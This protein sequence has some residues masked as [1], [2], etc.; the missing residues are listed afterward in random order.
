MPTQVSATVAPMGG[1]VTFLVSGYATGVGAQMT[2]GRSVGTSGGP[3]TALYSGSPVY[4][5]ID[6][7]D[8][9][10]TPLSSGS[11]YYW[12]FTDSAGSI[13]V[14]PLQPTSSIIYNPESL[15]SVI[16][17]CIQAGISNIT[18][19]AGIK[20]ATVMHSMPLGNFPP[21][22]LISVALRSQEQENNGIGQTARWPIAQENNVWAMPAL[23]RKIWMISI[24]AREV[25]TRD[26]Y[27]KVVLDILEAMLPDIFTGLGSNVTNSFLVSSGT[28]T[29]EVH[30]IAPGFY[31]ADI[32]M[33]LTGL[34]NVSVQLNYPPVVGILLSATASGLTV[35]GE[36]PAQFN[37]SYT[38]TP[39]PYTML[40]TIG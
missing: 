28:E 22:P 5:Y 25:D 19:P 3:Y 12:N 27:R 17:R 11:N 1:I 10:P 18:A 36:T 24:L 26:Y 35:F 33:E 32:M 38:G 9:L 37:P 23:A 29:D 4:F 8:G 21:L 39:N 2:V 20:P 31:Y 34:F 6:A 13:V 30:G 14:G 40:P 15:T 16:I 7:G